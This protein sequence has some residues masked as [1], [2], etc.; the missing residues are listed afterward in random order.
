MLDNTL[1]YDLGDEGKVL[2]NLDQVVM[3]G[4]NNG[5]GMIVFKNIPEPCHC[6]R[7]VVEAVINT[8]A[9]SMKAR[10]LPS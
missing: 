8:M 5:Q 1:V 9:R 2:I 7:A 4:L 6:P 10:E 3:A